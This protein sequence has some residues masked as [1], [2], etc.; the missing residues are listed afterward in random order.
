[1]PTAQPEPGTLFQFDTPADQTPVIA[2]DLRNFFAAL[3][4]FNY[5][6]DK[7]GPLD[8]AGNPTPAFPKAPR[9]GMARINASNPNNVKLE[10]WLPG[11][12]GGSRWRQALAFLQLGFGAPTKQVQ[13][14]ITPALVWT[15]DHNIGS[16]P[17]AMAIDT[18]G[19]VFADSG[20]PP[21]P[22]GAGQVQVQHATLNRVIFTFSGPTAG[23]AIIIG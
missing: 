17:L 5:T 23:T 13:Q 21:N 19:Y 11:T 16:F 7:T 22:I 3:A 8:L 9:D 10:F 1:M 6:T 20:P 4:R 15:I 2:R 14:V 18:S 12:G